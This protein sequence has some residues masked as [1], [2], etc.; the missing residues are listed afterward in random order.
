MAIINWKSFVCGTIVGGVIFSSISYASP[1]VVKLFVDGKEI[2]SEVPPQI[3]DG[4]TLI[5]ARALSEALG[6]KVEWDDVNR[7]VIVQS[8][9][10]LH[11]EKPTAISLQEVTWLLVRAQAHY[12]HTVSGGTL[13]EGKLT[14]FIPAGQTNDYRWLG[15]DID[16]KEKIL[17][18]W[19][20]AYIPEQA[21][22][23]LKQ[24]LEAKS[25]IE[26]DGKLAQPDADGGSLRNWASA[27]PVLLE[28]GT[29]RKV[30]K[31]TVPVGEPNGEVFGSDEFD[32]VLRF[33]K[34]QGWRIDETVGS[35]S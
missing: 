14:T 23:Y 21:E 11:P 1:A 3:I 34:G 10:Y 12:W 6:A 22:G 33:V 2:H 13:P 16:T 35:V 9:A 26:I 24:Q 17:A 31:V 15:S 8:E 7:T 28:D 29:V 20:E 30:Y 19:E 5:P 4:S 25:L 32:V 27:K 18:Y